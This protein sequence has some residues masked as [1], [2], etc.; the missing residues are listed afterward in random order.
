MAD[1]LHVAVPADVRHA[2]AVHHSATHILHAVLREVLGDHVTQA[3]SYVGPDYLRFDYTHFEAPSRAQRHE[4]VARV[5][6]RIRQAVPVATHLRP[7]DEAKAGGAIALFGEKYGEVV[8]VVE[9]ADFSV[10]LC[11]GTHLR[12]TGEIGAFHLLSE[13]S[14]AAGVRRIEALC[15]AQATG[16]IAEESQ[17]LS[18][19][20]EL[21]NVPASE[22]PARLRQLMDE[23]KQLEKRLEA[24]DRKRAAASAADLLNR[25][26]EVQGVPL[27]AAVLEGLDAAGLRDASDAL[28]QKL[29]D[30]ILVLGSATNGK[31]GLLCAVSPSLTGRIRAG[32]IIRPLAKLVGGGGGGKPELAQA[33]GKRPEALP[34]AIAAAP[35][36]VAELLSA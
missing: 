23:R 21:L 13:S 4:V 30:A 11:G 22:V 9:M 8:R 6:A 1:T 18:E 19:A 7:I 3:G 24:R 5:N 26:Q 28:R 16:R 34:D 2:T 14:I 27:L 20:A 25:V 35:G 10:E 12:N 29:P 32:D 36:V 15:G 33:G 31:V 17:V